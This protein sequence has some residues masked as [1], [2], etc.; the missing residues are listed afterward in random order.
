MSMND[1]RRCGS[2]I[3]YKLLPVDPCS[4]SYEVAPHVILDRRVHVAL[5]RN[6]SNNP[7]HWLC[8]VLVGEAPY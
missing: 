4:Y 3:T 2:H 7:M 5:R 8:L 1:S 6:L